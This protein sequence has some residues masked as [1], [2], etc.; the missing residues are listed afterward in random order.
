MRTVKQE[1]DR[2]TENT[3]NDKVVFFHSVPECDNFLRT[4]EHSIGLYS[5][6]LAC[7]HAF[8]ASV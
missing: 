4:R 7:I 8:S 5:V 3:G 2:R 1:L 6:S